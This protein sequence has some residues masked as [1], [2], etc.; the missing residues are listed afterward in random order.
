MNRKAA[1]VDERTRD[2]LRA[3]CN[4]KLLESQS[5]ADA[6]N[7]LLDR[8]GFPSADEIARDYRVV[9][10]AGRQSHVDEVG[11]ETQSTARR[12]YQS[13]SP[14]D[15]KSLPLDEATRDRLLAFTNRKPPEEGSYDFAVNELLDMAGVPEVEVLYQQYS[16]VWEVVSRLGSEEFDHDRF[17]SAA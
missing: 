17:G 3:Y 10:E 9:L 14:A 11:D 12:P 13:V 6:I 2:R 15:R 16:L 1:P 7:E 4:R 8:A 5:Y